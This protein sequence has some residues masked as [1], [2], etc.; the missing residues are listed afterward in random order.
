MKRW[1]AIPS[2]GLIIPFPPRY[3]DEQAEGGE[4]G[5]RGQ[6]V[7]SHLPVLQALCQRGGLRGGLRGLGGQ[8]RVLRIGHDGLEGGLKLLIKQV[9]SMFTLECFSAFNVPV[10]G[11]GLAH[12]SKNNVVY[13]KALLFEV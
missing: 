10:Y 3:E 12:Q 8:G 11:K 13:S 4:G 2:F 5:Q 6:D 7:E 1:T 9:V